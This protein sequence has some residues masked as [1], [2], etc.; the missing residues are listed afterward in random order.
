MNK[1]KQLGFSILGILLCALLLSSCVRDVKESTGS[2]T[3]KVREIIDV[4]SDLEDAFH[5]ALT[6]LKAQEYKQAIVLLEN[7]IEQEQRL[8]APF[9][10]LGMAYE[11]DGDV[12]QAEKYFRGAVS[13]DLTHPVANNQLGQLYR[14]LGRF[15]DA[16]K[17]Y[18]NA[19]T[20]YPDYLPVI[21]NLGILCELYIRDLPCALEQYQHYQNLQP[22][23]KTM[24]IWISD[25]SNRMGK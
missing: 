25:L 7:I 16:R 10:N 3:K 1:L 14:K 9:V 5:E 15:D 24:K 6:H 12:K 22:D 21:K 17:A 2:D 18:S 20:E 13:V 19:L 11:L 4:D 23:D 8:V